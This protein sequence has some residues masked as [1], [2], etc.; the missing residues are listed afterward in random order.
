MPTTTTQSNQVVLGTVQ[1]A[2][3]GVREDVAVTPLG[4]HT[5]I[6]REVTAAQQR[7]LGQHA[8]LATLNDF[9]SNLR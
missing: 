7:P 6:D 9:H 8:L 4:L 1:D 3:D 2:I 5:V